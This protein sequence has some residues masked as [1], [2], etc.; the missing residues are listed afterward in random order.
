MLK[1]ERRARTGPG[2]GTMAQRVLIVDDDIVVLRAV[3]T[4]LLEEGKWEVAMASTGRE[5]LDVALR[6]RPDVVVLDLGLPDM[7]GVAVCRELKALAGLPAPRV[8]VL[9]GQA[10]SATTAGALAAGADHYLLKPLSPHDLLR[11][12]QG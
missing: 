12:V 10:C 9:T 11:A 4:V 8:V 6:F 1:D 7:D 5:A 3:R 2:T